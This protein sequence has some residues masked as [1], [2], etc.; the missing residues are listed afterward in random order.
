M[1]LP[2]SLRSIGE[3]GASTSPRLPRWPS[4]KFE[5]LGVC[6]FCSADKRQH[7][8]GTIAVGGSAF[9]TKAKAGIEFPPRAGDDWREA[10][11]DF[12]F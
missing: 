11:G 7:L 12:A 4:P 3:E 1:T 2:D 6:A 10:I 9:S 5:T 8:G